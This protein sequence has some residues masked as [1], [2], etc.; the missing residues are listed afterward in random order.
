M[1][2]RG[3]AMMPVAGDFG[4]TMDRDS[5]MRPED[6]ER[7]RQAPDR[8]RVLMLGAATAASAISVRPALASTAASVLNCTI[9]VPDPGEGGKAVAADGSLVPVGTEGSYPGGRVFRGE[10]VREALRG[11]A[12]PGAGQAESKAYLNYIRRLQHGRSGFTCYAS[13]QMPR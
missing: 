1:D 6:G 3:H 13:L 8:R 7:D 9:P 5:P 2:N 12:L 10:D 4:R 11:R